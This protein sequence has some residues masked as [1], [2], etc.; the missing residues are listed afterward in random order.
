MAD[1]HEVWV[2]KYRPEKLSDIVGQNNIVERLETFVK[3]ESLPHL[4]FAGPPGNGKTTAALS[5]ARELF[6]EGWRQNFL[7]LNAS[8]ERGIDTVR[9]RIKDYARTRPVGDVPYKLIYLD[10]SDALTSQA[11]HALRRTM[12]MYAE[13]CRFILACNYSSKIIEPIQSRCA[14]FRFR[15][16]AE[17]DI[18]EVLK[19]IADEENLDLKDGGIDAIIYVSEG[20]MR[21]A[22]NV[23]QAASALEG[24]IDENVIYEVSA[25]ASPGEVR[26]MME[27]ALEGDFEKSRKKL[28]DLLID[29]G[30]AGDDVLQQIHREIFDL[31]IPEPMKVKLI[32]RVGEFDFRLVE[33]ANDRIQ[34]EAALAHL[35][36]L[37]NRMRS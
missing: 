36:R 33:G 28:T 5:I 27:S 12:E 34:L 23:L 3:K 18:A 11:Q 14:V 20:D 32:D 24:E 10:E 4:L 13:T 17:E 25:T 2:E 9:T 22:I 29:Q 21:R 15:R 35:A 31:D 16:L 6:G 30:L 1:E 7:E 37:G 26:K 19:R 8:D